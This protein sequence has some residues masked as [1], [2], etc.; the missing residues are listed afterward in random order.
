MLEGY[1]RQSAREKD[2]EKGTEIFR[3]GKL[4][5][6][7]IRFIMFNINMGHI[8]ESIKTKAFPTPKLL[9]TDHKKGTRIGDLPDRLVIQATNFSSTFVK[10]GYLSLTD[11]LEKNDIIY[12]RFTIV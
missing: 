6:D 4:L 1:L 11:I 10:V 3:Y 7:A 5:V 9:I 8:N 2:R 12:S